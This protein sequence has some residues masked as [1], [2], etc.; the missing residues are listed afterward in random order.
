M[1]PG[2]DFVCQGF[3]LD[4]VT[5]QI[6]KDSDLPLIPPSAYLLQG[7]CIPFG[8][9]NRDALLATNS[10]TYARTMLDRCDIPGADEILPPG[11]MVPTAPGWQIVLPQI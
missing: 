5:G 11:V 8:T 3:P 2:I 7:R 10:N 1:K 4:A 6:P 9:D